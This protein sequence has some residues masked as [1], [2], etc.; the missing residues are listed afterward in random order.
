MSTKPTYGHSKVSYLLVVIATP[1]S[2]MYKCVKTELTT[3]LQL[4]LF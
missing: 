1:A 4:Q 3:L 2:A